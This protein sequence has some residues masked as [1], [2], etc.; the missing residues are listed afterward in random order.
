MRLVRRLALGGRKTGC[1]QR[2]CVRSLCIEDLNRYIQVH[3]VASTDSLAEPS[4]GKTNS[5][6]LIGVQ[7]FIELDGDLID[8][9]I[10]GLESRAVHSSLRF[11][12]VNSS[13]LMIRCPNDLSFHQ[14]EDR[15]LPD[16]AAESLDQIGE[17]PFAA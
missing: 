1:K 16:V 6:E 15:L 3:A 7:K 4:Q 12:P 17:L 10:C 11:C 13:A 9:P 5:R 2:K 8:N 14:L